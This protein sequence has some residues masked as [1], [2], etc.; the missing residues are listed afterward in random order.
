[1]HLGKS[2]P[3]LEQANH[4]G[5]M[6]VVKLKV[7][8]KSFCFAPVLS[9]EIQIQDGFRC[10]GEGSSKEGVQAKTG[11]QS[12]VSNG[13]V[14]VDKRREIDTLL[15]DGDGS[16]WLVAGSPLR[17]VPHRTRNLLTVFQI[18]NPNS[19]IQNAQCPRGDSN[20]RPAV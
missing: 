6:Q 5:M 20:T 1:M 12:Y 10:D 16:Q 15:A 17:L 2:R 9:L 11:Q 8:R 3:N 18:Q 4:T 7:R 19:K 13:G 14:T